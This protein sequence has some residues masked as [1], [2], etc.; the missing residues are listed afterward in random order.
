MLRRSPIVNRVRL[1]GVMKKR[2][3]Q[4]QQIEVEAPSSSA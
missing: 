4:I 3:D 1:K 2:L